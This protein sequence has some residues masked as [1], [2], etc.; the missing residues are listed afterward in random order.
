MFLY[1][2]CDSLQRWGMSWFCWLYFWLGKLLV[3]WRVLPTLWEPEW[4]RLVTLALLFPLRLE[5][6]LLRYPGAPGKLVRTIR[7]RN[8][9]HYLSSF[10]QFG[11]VQ[12]PRVHDWAGRS[13]SA[14][15]H[16]SGWVGW[17][18]ENF[19]RRKRG[20]R[21]LLWGSDQQLDSDGTGEETQ[22]E[23]VSYS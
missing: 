7:I 14:G 15:L 9:W 20:G 12:H 3:I 18:Q 2:L 6:C 1:R 17:S 22:P 13:F 16:W 5:I 8:H 21:S 4:S 10:S 19:I 23:L 11:K